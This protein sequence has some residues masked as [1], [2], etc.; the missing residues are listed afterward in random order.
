MQV[1]SLMEEMM[2]EYKIQKKGMR[3]QGKNREEK[4]EKKKKTVVAAAV[5]KNKKWKATKK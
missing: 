3:H 2:K 1:M 4:Q 5:D